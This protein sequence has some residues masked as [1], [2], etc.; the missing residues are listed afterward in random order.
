MLA[1]WKEGRYEVFLRE[2]VPVKIGMGGINDGIITEAG[3]ERA[4]RALAMFGDVIRQ[5]SITNV[6]AF[7]TSAMRNARNGGDVAARMQSATG[8]DIRIISGDEEAEYIYQGVKMS[9]ALDSSPSLIVDIGGGSIEFI[10][11]SENEIRWK[12]SFEVGAQRLLERFHKHEPIL[13]EEVSDV[14]QFLVTALAPLLQQLTVLQPA[15]LVGSSGTFD[16]L[17]EIHCIRHG[18][19]YAESPVTPLTIESFR[20]IFQLLLSRNREE[21]LAI[22]GMIEMRVDMIVVACCVIQFLLD[23]AEFESVRVSTYS[24]KEGVLASLRS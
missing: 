7:G 16:T 9:G 3:V 10:I 8:F 21:R 15:V 24:L 20:E 14:R 22:P 13:P 4:L 18:I 19:P 2:R 23:H 5:H 1:R 11:G 17:S 12:R 6:F